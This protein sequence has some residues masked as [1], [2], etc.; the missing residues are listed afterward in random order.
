MSENESQN[1]SRA[2]WDVCVDVMV[3]Q[4]I[5]ICIATVRTPHSGILRVYLG[6]K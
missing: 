2:F 4:I 1:Q 3:K 6:L 5:I